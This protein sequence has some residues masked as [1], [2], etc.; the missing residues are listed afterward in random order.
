LLASLLFPDNAPKV[1]GLDDESV[2]DTFATILGG[3]EAVVASIDDTI[4]RGTLDVSDV[5]K[6]RTVDSL[7]PLLRCEEERIRGHASTTYRERAREREE[8]LCT[9]SNAHGQLS[10]VMAVLRHSKAAEPW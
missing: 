3:S 6:S 2:T 4:A 8:K 5:R 7:R 10:S 9:C 1:D